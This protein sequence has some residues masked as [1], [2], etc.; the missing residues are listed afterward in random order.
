[1]V[2]TGLILHKIRKVHQLTQREM[3][4]LLGVSDSLITRI[5]KGERRVTPKL[6]EVIVQEFALTDEKLTKILAIYDEYQC[7]AL[8]PS[9]TH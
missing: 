7:R 4:D 3:A 6:A 5:E 1:M 8:Q 2:L 9:S